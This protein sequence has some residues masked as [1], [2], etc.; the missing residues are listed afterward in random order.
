M[1][2]RRVLGGVAAGLALGAAVALAQATP[3]PAAPAPGS[4]PPTS[5]ALSAE[6]V[7]KLFSGNTEVTTAMKRGVATGRVYKAYHLPD[8]TYRL[9][10][11]NGQRGGGS[12]FV[13]PL[14]R[15]C[16][17]VQEKD[18]TKCDVIVREGDHYIRLRDGERRG[19]MTI[20]KG[21]PYNL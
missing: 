12:W 11:A 3:E 4:A 10:E 1:Q 20:E 9:S 6:E 8:G 5:D 13:D 17:R 19:Q 21:N 7:Q 15:H 2:A 16:F 14:G 18:K